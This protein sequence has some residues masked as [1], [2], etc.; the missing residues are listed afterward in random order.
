[1][2]PFRWKPTFHSSGREGEFEETQTFLE[3][4]G[5][6]HATPVL[7]LAALAC[8]MD[9]S[10]SRLLGGVDYRGAI[11]R[12]R[13]AQGFDGFD[14]CPGLAPEAFDEAKKAF[15]NRTSERFGKTAPIIG[16]LAD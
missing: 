7:C 16:R 4:L 1:M 3:L 9:R 6:A 14:E 12:A 10:A 8:C 13:A 15:D 5:V 11:Y 2:R